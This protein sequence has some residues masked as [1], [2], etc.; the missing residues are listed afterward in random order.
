MNNAFPIT[1][2]PNAKAGRAAKGAARLPPA[3]RRLVAAA[4][5]PGRA[6]PASE[7]RGRMAEAGQRIALLLG[8]EP[9]APALAPAYGPAFA[10]VGFAGREHEA[11]EGACPPAPPA[12]HRPPPGLADAPP[13]PAAAPRRRLRARDAKLEARL[14]E[15]GRELE[16]TRQALDASRLALESL[17]RREREAARA[18]ELAARSHDELAARVAGELGA[19]LRDLLKRARR[20]RDEHDPAALRKALRSLERRARALAE[21]AE[22]LPAAPRGRPG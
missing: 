12:P 15:Q 14:A 17:S 2:E 16:A 4:P 18:A 6:K 21:A 8:G 3:P 19:P 7:L 10:L 13:E 5:P 1:D 20:L 22:A 9:P 11:D